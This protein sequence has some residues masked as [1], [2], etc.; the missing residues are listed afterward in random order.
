MS[1]SDV[2]SGSGRCVIPM[3][4]G[5]VSV[6]FWILTYLAKYTFQAMERETLSIQGMSPFNSK[7]WMLDKSSQVDII[8]M[9]E[10]L[11]K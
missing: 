4:E 3:V 6:L 10:G 5:V 9:T 2:T 11:I 8:I 7:I 1:L